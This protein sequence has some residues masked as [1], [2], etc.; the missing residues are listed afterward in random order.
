MSQ[1]FSAADSGSSIT[2][3]LGEVFEV[4]LAE[5]PT[6]AYR[7]H[8]TITPPKAIASEGN[9]LQS[10]SKA[11]G[12]GGERHFHFRAAQAGSFELAC[13]RYRAWESAASAT[14][15][16]KLTGVVR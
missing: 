14:E 16:F 7:W 5:N 12:A 3:D 11:V 15:T 10:Q 9:D 6:T 2:L 13:L 1:A 4:A 8:V